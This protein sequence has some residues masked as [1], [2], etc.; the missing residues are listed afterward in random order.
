DPRQG[1]AAGVRHVRQD[2]FSCFAHGSLVLGKDCAYIDARFANDKPCPD[3]RYHYWGLDCKEWTEFRAAAATCTIVRVLHL[4]L[5]SLVSGNKRQ[6]FKA[7]HLLSVLRLVRYG[8]CC[9]SRS[10]SWHS[11]AFQDFSPWPW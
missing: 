3:R 11:C 8:R 6:C 1:P 7:L 9:V 2:L 10:A 5:G 4:H